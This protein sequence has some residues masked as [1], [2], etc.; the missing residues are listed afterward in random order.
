MPGPWSDAAVQT[1]TGTRAC[2]AVATI[3]NYY[4]NGVPLFE[5]EASRAEFLLRR[6]LSRSRS[7]RRIRARPDPRPLP[8]PGPSLPQ[9]SGPWLHLQ[10]QLEELRV[11]NM[12]L[13]NE[14]AHLRAENQL[15][16]AQTETLNAVLRL[17]EQRCE[18]QW[19]LLLRCDTSMSRR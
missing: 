2:G 4:R 17:Y 9:L 14:N 12:Q 10:G 7:R 19:E 5:M 13:R 16:E 1:T 3:Q 6:A 15:L 11:E 18:R 8:P